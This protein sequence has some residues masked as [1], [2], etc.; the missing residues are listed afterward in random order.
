MVKR[1]IEINGVNIAEFIG[2]L[3][4]C[5]GNVYLETKEGDCINLK[6]RLSALIGLAQIIKGGLISG[7]TLRC[8]NPDDE[9]KLFRFALFREIAGDKDEK[10][11]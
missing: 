3:E 5:T 6:S 2:A 8:E 9:S 7:A 4:S 1:E 11:A 10:S